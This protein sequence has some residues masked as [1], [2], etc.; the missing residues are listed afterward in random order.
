V[1]IL[2]IG[3]DERLADS[4]KFELKEGLYDVQYTADGETG[5]MTAKKN[6]FD[7]IVLDWGLIKKDGLSVLK[8]L[9]EQKIMI[10]ILMLTAKDSVGEVVVSLN[11]GA[12]ACVSKPLEIKVLIA[13]LN[14]LVRRTKWDRGAEI[15]IAPIRLDPVAHK[16]WSDDEEV[17]LTAV[18]YSL[19]LYFM[20]N[21]EQVVTRTMIAENVW[22]NAIDLSKNGI[23]V[24]VNYLRNKIDNGLGKNLI[25][26]VRGT[27]YVFKSI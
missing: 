17:A 21:P 2:V 8:E 9:R 23:D 26:T 5:L 1:N 15:C 4:L 14:A 20:Q 16:V 10:P 6:R 25:H 3:N 24:Y 11:S 19:L 7:L 18:E 22:G 13:R 12:D 27:G